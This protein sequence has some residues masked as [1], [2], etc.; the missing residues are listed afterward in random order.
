[1]TECVDVE[2]ILHNNSSD[3]VQNI[4]REGGRA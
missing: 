3:C 2:V 1:M 4:Q